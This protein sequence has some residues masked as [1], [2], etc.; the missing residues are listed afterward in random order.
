MEK[1][2]KLYRQAALNPGE[3]GARTHSIGYCMGTGIHQDIWRVRNVFP[4]PGIKPHFLG[5][6]T[7]SLVML[8]I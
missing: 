7:S 2:G 4:L 6:P 8:E 5:Y 3:K 1:S